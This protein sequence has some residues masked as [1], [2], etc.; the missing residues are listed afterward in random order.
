MKRI[1]CAT[2]RL[3]F[4][5]DFTFQ[6]AAEI[7]DYLAE[8]GVSDLYASPLFEAGPQSTHGYDTCCFGKINPQLGSTEDFDRLTSA[9]TERG[10]GLLLDI[11]PNHM[12]ATVANPWWLDVLENGR[13]SPYAGFFDINWRPN[14]PALHE[15]VL[16]PVL[17][18]HYAKV[19]ESGKLRLTCARGKFFISYYDRNFP[20]NPASIGEHGANDPSRVLEI[21]NG[22]PGNARSFD[23]LDALIQR[24]RY[25]LAYWRVASEE[26]NYRRFFDVTEM[27]AL[28]MESPEV[29]RR[30]HELIFN[31]LAAGKVTGLRIDHPDG[32]WDPKEYLARLQGAMGDKKALYVVVEKIL[33]G[34][35]PLPADWPVEGTTGYDFLNRVNGLF[36][37]GSNASAFNETY[38]E[39]TGVDREF[40]EIA[41]HSRKQVLE[42]SFASELNA[43]THRLKDIAARTRAGRAFTFS[44]LHRATAEIIANF[45]VYR[46]YITENSTEVSE[47]DRKVI[48][49]AMRKARERTGV[50]CALDFIEKI[51]LLE[52]VA[53]LEETGL[54]TTRKFVMKFQQLTGPAM[55]KGLED[56]AF[57]RF[58]RL[59]SLNEVG[60]EPGRFGVSPAEFHEANR[61]IASRWPHTILASATHDT[62]RGEDVR[63]RLN[64]LSE[65]PE[66]WRETLSRWSQINRDKKAILKNAP[67]PD[68]NA[69]YLLY[70]T[71]VGA[72]PPDADKPDG[73]K[74][75]RSRISAFMLKA[76]KEAKEHTSW[77]EPNGAYEKALQDFI[78][79]VLDD[80][81]EIFLSDLRRFAG[82]IAFF[83]RFNS[84]AQTLLKITSPGV[85]DFYQG[86]E[87]WDLN[88]VDPDNRRPVD[89]ETS[90]KLLS[91]LKKKFEHVE[92]G[93]REFFPA[94][95]QNEN[96]AA[97]KLFLI[98]RALIFRQ[99]H[100]ELFECGDYIP[101]S[102]TG[103]KRE[104]VVA[105]ARTS[106]DRIAL[107]VVP[108]LIFGLTR[109][110]G[111]P[112]IG[113]ELWN[114]TELILPH[115]PPGSLFRNVFTREMVT[116][117]ERGG[118]F[119][120]EMGKVLQSFPVALLEKI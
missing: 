5:R 105:F 90:R 77:T 34:N 25:R 42:R 40:D 36:V 28:K 38:R 23:K 63:A 15:K 47:Q 48:R 12:S 109:G 72:W 60:G 110:A 89:Y 24:Q 62:K 41:Y 11:V 103:E 76:A 18:D 86:S 55:A 100:R 113:A 20:V 96:S 104:H 22:K 117:I 21:L 93:A 50:A 99:S 92:A 44:E 54:R 1:P 106:K 51:L 112:P 9:L 84:L 31:W 114:A 71:L 119:A 91:D 70:Q 73:L 97:M 95:L 108:R 29:F 85:P 7:L 4:N 37:D 58:N 67:E 19:L 111:V 39:F 87:L 101:L 2:Y 35:E 27:V 43:L 102:A 46:T 14:N 78:G 6:Q 26:I 13:A 81:N 53:E 94:F 75:F 10:I 33:S 107:V 116:T 83:G 49:E 79:R 74:M 16:L 45:P 61:A 30:T 64:V 56:T 17:E 66:K 8:L 118:K 68:S 80:A 120:L 3:Q 98:W 115:I 65:M 88:L 32:L 57:Y 52:I 59:V 69:E 82:P